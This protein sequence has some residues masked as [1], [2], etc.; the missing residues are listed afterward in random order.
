MKAVISSG[1]AFI[2]KNDLEKKI[3]MNAVKELEGHDIDDDLYFH[4][5]VNEIDYAQEAHLDTDISKT[6]AA[7]EI[8]YDI[9]L[10]GITRRYTFRWLIKKIDRLRDKKNKT[11][12][13]N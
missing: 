12:G 1:R 7:N 2:P 11:K 8:M 5:F 4:A 13:P 9:Y 10:K 6:V 3:V